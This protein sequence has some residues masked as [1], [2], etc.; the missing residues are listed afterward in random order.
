MKTTRINMNDHTASVKVERLE[1]AEIKYA[2]F[3]LAEYYREKELYNSADKAMKMW[4]EM[5]KGFER[6]FSD[7]Y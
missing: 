7:V 1:F 4:G 6:L 5:D 3:K 2:L